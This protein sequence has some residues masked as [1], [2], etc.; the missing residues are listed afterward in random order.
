LSSTLKIHLIEKLF[1]GRMC[2]VAVGEIMGKAQWTDAGLDGFRLCISTRCN[3]CNKQNNDQYS[4]FHLFA[5]VFLWLPIFMY[6][7]APGNLKGMAQSSAAIDHFTFTTSSGL[8]VWSKN[9]TALP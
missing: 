9:S 4:S 6:S 7:H 2:R 8:Q 1:A 5:S 3:E